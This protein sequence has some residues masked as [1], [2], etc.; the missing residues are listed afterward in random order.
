MN[1]IQMLFARLAMQQD[2][3][4][5]M[6][7]DWRDPMGN[8]WTRPPAQPPMPFRDPMQA[9]PAPPTTGPIASLFKG[10]P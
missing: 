4:A 6:P 7:Q 2:H 3:E 5:Q 10:R 9:G 1:P 8:I